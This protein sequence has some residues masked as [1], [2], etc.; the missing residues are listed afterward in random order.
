MQEAFI[1]VISSACFIIGL[2]VLMSYIKNISLQLTVYNCFKRESMIV[3]PDLN[4]LTKI[5]YT[6]FNIICKDID[7]PLS[8]DYIWSKIEWS[9]DQSMNP[10]KKEVANICEAMYEK[11]YIDKIQGKYTVKFKE[12]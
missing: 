1:S 7:C 9:S 8:S 3:K 10:S 6:I 2:C 4:E 11:G 12:Q 5:E